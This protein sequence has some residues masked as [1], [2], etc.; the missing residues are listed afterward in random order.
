MVLLHRPYLRPASALP[1]KHPQSQLF[2]VGG[3][4]WRWC[5]G[6]WVG[7]L[8]GLREGDDFANVLFTYEQRG[9]AVNTECEAA[10]GWRSVLERVEQEAEL[11]HCLLYTSDA[12]DE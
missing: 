2:H 8:L 7:T 12:A 11:G 10:M 1:R 6:E 3:V 9:E 4:G 5:L